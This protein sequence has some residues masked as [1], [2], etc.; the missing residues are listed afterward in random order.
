MPQSLQEEDGRG[1]VPSKIICVCYIPPLYHIC[2]WSPRVFLFLFVL[3]LIAQKQGEGK[4]RRRDKEAGRRKTSLLFPSPVLTSKSKHI[5]GHLSRDR[6]SQGHPAPKD[7]TSKG[8]LVIFLFTA[9]YP[10][11]HPHPPAPCPRPPP[12]HLQAIASQH[13]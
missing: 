8:I 7:S 10:N 13:V 3:M 9:E 2:L 4:G 11:E 6:W 1:P 12:G 5:Q